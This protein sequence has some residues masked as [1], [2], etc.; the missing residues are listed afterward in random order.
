MY[1]LCIKNSNKRVLHN[2]FINLIDCMPKTVPNAHKKLNCDYAIIQ[3]S[4]TEETDFETNS[5]LIKKLFKN[6]HIS[7]FE[8]IKFKF[9]VKAPIFI[10]NKLFMYKK[11]N[12]HELNEINKNKPNEMYINHSINKKNDEYNKIFNIDVSRKNAI[13]NL[14]L[15]VF[16]EFYFCIDLHNLLNFIKLQN[17]WKPRY[18]IKEYSRAFEDIISPL[19]PITI[20]AYN[21]YKTV[22]ITNYEYK[23]LMKID[24]K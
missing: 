20:E 24:K 9:H 15:N 19:C 16:T 2:G 14:P 8:L 6:K 12:Y 23:K 18:E 10:A 21:E 17:S 7:S 5:K 13:I 4:R 22:T 1:S 3:A 11:S